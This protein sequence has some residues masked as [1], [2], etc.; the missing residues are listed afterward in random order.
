MIV[1]SNSKRGFI[2]DV[3]DNLIA[4][5]IG[6]AFKQKRLPIGEA[7]FRSWMNSL[8]FMRNGIDD[9]GIS[10]DCRLAIEYQIPLTS[11]RVDFLIS[12]VDENQQNNVVVVELKQWTDCMP[13]SRP[14]VVKAFTGGANRDVTHPCYQAYSYA[15]IMETFNEDVYKNKINIIPCAYLHNFQEENREHITSS[16]EDALS[17]ASM[18]LSRD[19]AAL[20]AF[21]KRYIK[22]KDGIDILMKIEHGKLKPAKSLQDALASMLDGNQEFYLIDEQKVAYETIRR[23]LLKALNDKDNPSSKSTVIVKGGPGTG[24]SVVAIQ[25]LCDMIQHGYSAAYTTKNSAPRSVYFAK[26]RKNSF[27][28]NYLKTLFV[29]SGSFIEAQS[30]QFDCL[31]ADEA[32]RLQGKTLRGRYLAG[33]NQV[34]EIIH[35]SRLSVFFIDEEQKVTGSDICDVEMIRHY[36]ELEGSSVYEDESINLVSQFRCNGSNGYLG[37]VDSLLGYNEVDYDLDLE[38]DVKVFDDPCQMREA[39]RAKNKVANK[40]R[41]LAGYCYNWITKEDSSIDDYDIQ[42]ENGFKAKWN[43]KETS[44]WAIDET[45]FDQVG[46]IHTSQGLEFDYVGLIIGPDLQFKDGK[47]ITDKARR[48]DTDSSLNGATRNPE[49]CD[50]LIRNTYRTLLTRGMKGCYIYCEDKALGQHIKQMLM[51]RKN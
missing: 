16:Y 17:K 18:F 14:D 39:V 47:V 30:N 33:E 3:R 26:L 23:L 5:K 8:Q 38:Y 1:Y 2:D 9:S 48:A 41:M 43:F 42:L 50:M 13:T 45:S 32:H 31:L 24:K 11:K 20:W 49:V 51:R 40:S 12:G 19:T 28:L 21:I 4:D 34:R 27:K 36:A 10:D 46:C 37:F 7:E 22:K 29:S 25:L 15:K 35:A 44:T 6:L